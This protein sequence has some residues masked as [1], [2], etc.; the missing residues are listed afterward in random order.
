M[1]TTVRGGA[2][3]QILALLVLCAVGAELLTAYA[4]TTGNPARVAFEVVFFAALYGAPALVVRDVVRRRGWGWPSLL[5]LFAALGVT[6][7][8][9]IDQSLF[10]V[11]YQGYEGWEQTRSATLVPAL[12]V[13][14]FNV[15][16]FFVGHVIF[17]FGAPMAVAEAW[18]PARADR[19]WLGRLGR[20]VALA[21]YLATAA[22]IVSDAQSRSGSPTQ[23]AT[24]AVVVALL[25][26]AA[27]GWGRRGRPQSDDRRPLRARSAFLVAFLAAAVI[28]VCPETWVGVSVAS[29]T[30]ALL[31]GWL[32]WISRRRS[33]G[34]RA[35]AAVG[36]A[37]LVVRGLLAFT[38]FPLAGDVAAGPKYAHNVVMMLVVV[39]AGALALRRRTT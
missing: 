10:S 33:V 36:L 23:L 13:S 20:V 31:A 18:A 38:Y 22:L 2:L 15:F 34:L 27:V 25:V 9:L 24:S 17:S 12:G 29:T 37:F 39:L 6:Q 28:A 8:A 21:A 26:I 5:L 14:A 11:D 19:P 16:N 1:S 32:L 30:T 3:A 7:A 4:A 35:I